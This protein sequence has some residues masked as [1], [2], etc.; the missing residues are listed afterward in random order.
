MSQEQGFPTKWEK[1]LPT[2]FKDDAESLDTDGLKQVIISSEGNI[3]TIE[4]EMAAD[5]KLKAAKDLVKDLSGAY[6]DGI[7]AQMAKIKYCLYLM[8]T[9]G[10][11]L[12][13]RD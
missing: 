3:S 5:E 9:R 1:K 12:D 13:N 11:D 4:K 2:G 6:K 8:E 7:S 10:E